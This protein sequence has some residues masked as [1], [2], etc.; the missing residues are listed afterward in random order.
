MKLTNT[1]LFNFIGRI[2]LKQENMAKYRNQINNLRDRL[3]GKIDND[4]RTDIK[5]T[6]F[7]IAGS[8]AKHLILRPTG[9]HPI[10][11]D[12]VL[13][14]EG[15]ET[16]ENDLQKLHDYVVS[17]LQDIYPNKDDS[18]IIADG[19]TK[20]IKIIFV[21]T[22]LEVDIVPVVPLKNPPQYVRQPERGGGGRYI[23]S[24]SKQLDF[25]TERRTKNA[26]FSAIVRALK[27]WRNYK[28][29]KPTDDNPGLSSFN[30]ELIVAYLDINHGV[31]TNIE[32]GIIRAF[33]FM[34]DP[35]FPVLSFAMAIN[36]VPAVRGPIYIADPTNN[37]NNTAKKVDIKL[38]DEIKVEANDAYESLVY[39]QA[40]NFEGDTTDEWKRVF[41]PSF[42]ITAEN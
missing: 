27:W 22:G 11:I 36:S 28:E 2:K 23:T 14:I 9:D 34:S 6:K 35:T 25:T 38:W 42:N 37:E 41:G 19:K 30:I 20:A 40:R 31:E 33:R 10:D 17:Y 3:Q 18:E 26:S 24:V 12:L 32:E 5:V 21:G 8:W 4:K 15:S 1:Q 13:Y 7:T 39:A 29:L 16:L